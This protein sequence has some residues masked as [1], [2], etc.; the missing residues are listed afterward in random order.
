MIDVK[1]AADI[2]KEYLTSFFPDGENVQ[3][4]EVELSQDKKFWKI[5][6]S[7]E[8]VAD[9]VASSMLV[10]KSPKFKVFTLDAKTGSVISMKRRDIK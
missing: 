6:L 8:G 4:E 7:F 5:T 1:K 10:G 3:L 9:A 2:A